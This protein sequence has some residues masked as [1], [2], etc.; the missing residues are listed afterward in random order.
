MHGQILDAGNA[1]ESGL[2]ILPAFLPAFEPFIAA[3]TITVWTQ[4]M[5]SAVQ[6]REVTA[7]ICSL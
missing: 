3:M 2:V 5:R 6:A 1:G 7:V 4:V